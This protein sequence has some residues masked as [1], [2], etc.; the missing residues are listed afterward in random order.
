MAY[1]N[2]GDVSSCLEMFRL[3]IGLCRIRKDEPFLVQQLVRIAIGSLSVQ[4]IQQVLGVLPVDEDLIEFLEEVVQSVSFDESYYLSMES[5]RVYMAEIWEETNIAELLDWIGHPRDYAALEYWD[6]GRYFFAMHLDRKYFI[7]TIPVEIEYLSRPYL[8]I[9][10]SEV[11]KRFQDVPKLFF[12]SYTAIEY[13]INTRKTV[14]TMNMNLQIATL[15]LQLHRMQLE[16][17]EFPENLDGLDEEMMSDSFSGERLRYVKQENGFLLY[18]V[19]KNGIDDGGVKH[20]GR[21]QDDLSL[22]YSFGL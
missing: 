14:E 4:T 17:G 18:S 20:P 19:G 10:W 5:E 15:A 16:T 9:D 7:E 22:V 13:L 21:K 8:E 12:N 1:A 6:I 2:E 3:N 11:E